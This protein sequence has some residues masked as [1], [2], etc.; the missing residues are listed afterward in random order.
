MGN[1]SPSKSQTTRLLC[2]SAFLLGLSYY[3]EVLGYLEKENHGV[4][5]EL[6]TDMGLIARVC[7]FAKAREKRFQI[8]L[9][10][11]SI[12]GF[13]VFLISQEVGIVLFVMA[14]A[15]M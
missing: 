2:A 10:F 14:T 6:G 11:V 15:L 13:L 8:Y 1:T 12:G 9:F 7:Q 5:P 3:R 4:S